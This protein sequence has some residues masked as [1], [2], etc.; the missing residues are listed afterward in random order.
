MWTI[1]RFVD[2]A[3]LQTF[4][5]FPTVL[6]RASLFWQFDSA[7]TK[8]VHKSEREKKK[9]IDVRLF[10]FSPSPPTWTFV[11]WIPRRVFFPYTH[12]KISKEKI[13][14][15]WT[16]Y[17][18]SPVMNYSHHETKQLKSAW[19]YVTIDFTYR[20]IKTVDSCS[21]AYLSRKKPYHV[22]V[23]D[24]GMPVLRPSLLIH[25]ANS[26]TRVWASKLIRGTFRSADGA[27]S[28]ESLKKWTLILLIFIAIT[29]SDIK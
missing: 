19:E 4:S 16:G 6:Q 12:S 26:R 24:L 18:R 5:L 25:H 28:K 11:Q 27:P 7:R 23:H 15:L 2:V 13:E 29:L 17:S 22:P 14:G 3:C 21:R 1:G 20:P 10:L 8:R 9:E